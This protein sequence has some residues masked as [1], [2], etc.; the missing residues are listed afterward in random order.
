MF[1]EYSGRMKSL[2]LY[3]SGLLALALVSSAA[4][5]DLIADGAK[6]EVLSEGNPTVAVMD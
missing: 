1:D 5:T 2:P 3:V 6:V 4:D